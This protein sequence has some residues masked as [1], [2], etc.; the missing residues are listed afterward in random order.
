MNPSPYEAAI[1]PQWQSRQPH[2]FDDVCWRYCP[3]VLAERDRADQAEEH[4]AKLQESH[5]LLIRN[6]SLIIDQKNDLIQ[7]NRRLRKKLARRSNFV[8]RLLNME[9]ANRREGKLDLS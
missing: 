3:E 9:R 2:V 8:I 6:Y 4:V 7:E 1:S 5:G